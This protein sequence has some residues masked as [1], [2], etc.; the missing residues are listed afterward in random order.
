MLYDEHTFCHNSALKSQTAAA[1]LAEGCKMPVS[2]HSIWH[3]SS[4]GLRRQHHDDCGWRRANRR[5]LGNEENW[6]GNQSSSFHEVDEREAA[7]W[8]YYHLIH[9]H[10]HHH[11]W[12]QSFRN[13]RTT[14]PLMC[15]TG[16]ACLSCLST[17]ISPTAVPRL[18]APPALPASV[19]RRRHCRAWR[20]RPGRPAGRRRTCPCYGR[21]RHRL[22]RA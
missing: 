8:W 19:L 3:R 4:S 22:R 20:P 16:L 5:R 1:V 2:Q 12:V 9:H 11:I 14:P 13:A 21:R 18:H 10:Y 7:R 15:L 17:F 6:E